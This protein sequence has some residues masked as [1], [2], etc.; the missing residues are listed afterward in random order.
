MALVSLSASR[1]S[2]M[3]LL[4]NR[5]R[6]S[7]TAK[8]LGCVGG[9][10]AYPCTSAPFLHSTLQSHPPLKPVWPVTNTRLSAQ[11]DSTVIVNR[12]PEMGL[13]DVAQR[14]PRPRLTNLRPRESKTMSRDCRQTYNRTHYE[15]QTQSQQAKSR[16]Q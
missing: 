6:R 15:Q 9:S 16:E 10:S 5:E 8:K 3:V 11:N 7:V 13:T 1:T 2:A 12:S 4:A 14:V